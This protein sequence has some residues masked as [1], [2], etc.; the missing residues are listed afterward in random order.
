MTEIV[1]LVEEDPEGGYS[2]IRLEATH[3]SGSHRL[4][5]SNHDSIKIGTLNYILSDVA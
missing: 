1:F 5:V 3:P 4:T 2:A